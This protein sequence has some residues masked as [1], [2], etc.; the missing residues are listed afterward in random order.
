MHLERTADGYRVRYAI[1]DVAAFVEPGRARSTSRRT[2]AARRSTRP[3]TASPL[4]P[5]GAL[6]GRGSL[7]PDQVRPALLW[8]IDL[9]AEAS[10]QVYVAGPGSGAGA[11][12]LCRRPG[13]VDAGNARP[14]A[15]L[16]EVGEL[17]LAREQERGGI[18]LPLPEQE[19]VVGD[20]GWSLTLP[21]EAAGRGL[22]RA[23]LPAHGHGGR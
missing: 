20:D 8:S 7:L 23:D 10:R 21:R 9:D 3:T 22:E 5:A 14:L 11:A 12:R 15:L 1:A 19:V 6:G 13:L 16:K 17:R 18:S 2:A 4:L